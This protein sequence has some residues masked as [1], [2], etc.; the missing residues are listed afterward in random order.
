MVLKLNGWN[1]LYVVAA[2]LWVGACLFYFYTGYPSDEI[3]RVQTDRAVDARRAAA[4]VAEKN[5]IRKVCRAQFLIDKRK[6]LTSQDLND[7][8]N[9]SR[10][11][12][13][14]S[15]SS[16]R[17]SRALNNSIWLEDDISSSASDAIES[18][19]EATI[20]QGSSVQSLADDVNQKVEA[21]NQEIPR[22]RVQQRSFLVQSMLVTVGPLFLTYILGLAVMWVRR[23]FSS[24][25]ANEEN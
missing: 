6:T 11:M 22:Y 3:L 13:D 7:V 18:C 20:G 4:K 24:T 14:P 8:E 23:G 17:R 10:L 19:V 15:V 1:R 25:Q 16:E 12:L 5:K 2:V 21:F 9:S